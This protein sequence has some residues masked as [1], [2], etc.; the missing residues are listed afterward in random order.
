MAC[1]N[2]IGPMTSRYRW[3]G[4]I[5]E[6]T[7]VLLLMKTTAAARES[8]RRRIGEIHSYDVPE[9]LEFGADG[10]LPE[11]LHWVSASCAAPD[12]A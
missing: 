8:L 10:G 11:Y 3:E 12:G 2:F 7:E 9:V 1:V 5:D 6:G 4:R